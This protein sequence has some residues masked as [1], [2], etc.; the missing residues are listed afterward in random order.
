MTQPTER[1]AVD[2]LVR[3]AAKSAAQFRAERLGG[4]SAWEI[5]VGLA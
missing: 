1:W 5:Q 4:S 3:D 2:E